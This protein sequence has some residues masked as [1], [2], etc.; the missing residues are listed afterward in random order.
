MDPRLRG[1]DKLNNGE[2]RLKLTPTLCPINVLQWVLV[3]NLNIEKDVE[4]KVMGRKFP[5]NKNSNPMDSVDTSALDDTSWT[6]MPTQLDSKREARPTNKRKYESLFQDNPGASE[7]S[8][9]DAPDAKA[10]PLSDT[11]VN[12]LNDG[13]IKIIFDALQNIAKTLRALDGAGSRFDAI[14][15]KLELAMQTTGLAS[16]KPEPTKEAKKDVSGAPA[17]VYQ[18][19]S[20][21]SA[22]EEAE[23]QETPVEADNSPEAVREHLRVLREVDDKLQGLM[24][25]YGARMPEDLRNVLSLL[26]IEVD[27]SIE[28]VEKQEERLTQQEDMKQTMQDERAAPASELR[29]MLTEVPASD[30]SDDELD[31]LVEQQEAQFTQQENMKQSMQ[32]QR[33]AQPSARRSIF[34][35]VPEYDADEDSDVEDLGYVNLGSRRNSFDT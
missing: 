12:M 7:A 30:E 1:D 13:E 20:M 14:H 26:R 9:A 23:A 28:L 10:T 29:S 19:N 15:A 35:K 3:Y 27:R 31:A 22:P 5:I 18:A 2:V 8:T 21:A 11:N 17:P 34:T 16:D 4:E 6:T 32:E 25:S 24:T 33:T